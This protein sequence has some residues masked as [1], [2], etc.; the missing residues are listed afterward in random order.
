MELQRKAL[1]NKLRPSTVE[2]AN[3]EGVEE[4]LVLKSCNLA[5]Y[6]L[7]YLPYPHQAMHVSLFWQVQ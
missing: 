2:R 6:K 7:R 3:K 4:K 1:V 5:V